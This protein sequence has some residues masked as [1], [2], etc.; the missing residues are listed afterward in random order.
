MLSA[1]ARASSGGTVVTKKVF[2]AFVLIAISLD[3]STLGWLLYVHTR[4][5]PALFL[6]A[7]L[8]GA[9]FLLEPEPYLKGNKITGIWRIFIGC[10]FLLCSIASSLLVMRTWRSL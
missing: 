5:P 2:G 1:K 10:I 3:G 9:Y 7:A 8:L 6:N 4:F